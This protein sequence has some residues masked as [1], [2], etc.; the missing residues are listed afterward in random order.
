MCELL[1]YEWKLIAWFTSS[2]SASTE[3]HWNDL[4][5][6]DQNLI[7]LVHWQQQIIDNQICTCDYFFSHPVININ[8][9]QLLCSNSRNKYCLFFIFGSSNSLKGDKN[10]SDGEIREWIFF[11]Q[12]SLVIAARNLDDWRMDLLL[13][14]FQ[15][16]CAV[17]AVVQHTETKVI[18]TFLNMKMIGKRLVQIVTQMWPPFHHWDF[19]GKREFKF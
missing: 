8:N 5:G 2:R 1:G 4:L 7:C 14:L 10:A 6:Y 9:W 19:L 15:V 16:G 18:N 3:L 17:C 11:S 12:D 13:L